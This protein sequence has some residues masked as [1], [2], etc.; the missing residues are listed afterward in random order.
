[1]TRIKRIRITTAEFR[2][3]CEFQQK[4]RWDWPAVFS[5]NPNGDICCFQGYGYKPLSERENLR[6]ASP[7]LDV[8]ADIYSEQREEC[9]RFFIDH[10]GAFFKNDGTEV[11]FVQWDSGQEKLT[12]PASTSAPEG[13]QMT[14][15]ELWAL[16][17][18]R[19]LAAV[20]EKR[21]KRLG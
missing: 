3:F 8:V 13:P 2:E 15:S 18:K 12:P 14:Q 10:R 4:H 1:M 11:Q 5:T 9:G 6:E 20:E 7:L 21:K 19:R 16:M 17:E